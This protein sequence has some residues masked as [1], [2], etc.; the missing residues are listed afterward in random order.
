MEPQ[1]NL[2]DL[3]PE[4]ITE[5]LYNI[6][7]L[8]TLANLCQTDKRI[9]AICENNMFWKEKYRR[10]F[11]HLPSEVNLSWKE[12]YKL[13]LLTV[14]ISPISS[15]DNSYAIIDDQSM[16]YIGGNINSLTAISNTSPF[17]QKVRSVSQASTYTG[18]VTDDGKV[19]FWGEKLQTIFNDPIVRKPTEFKIPG[20]A[21]KISCGPIIGV[22]SAMFAVILEDRSV[23]LRMR[24]YFIDSGPY[25]SKGGIFSAKINITGRDGLKRNIKALDISTN[26]H[27]LAIVSTSGKLYYLGKSLNTNTVPYP[28][29][30]GDVGIIYKDGEIVVNPVHIHLP[31]T[32]KQVSLDHTHI[33]VL[34]FKGT[35]YLWG[36]NQYGQL[37]Q[38]K[39]LE[40]VNIVDKPLKLTLPVPIS[41][42]DCRYFT[43]SAIDKNGKLY[44]WGKHKMS[45][46]PSKYTG[47]DDIL[48][49]SEYYLNSGFNRPI[50]IGLR[51]NNTAM[52]NIFNYVSIGW[53]HVVATTNDGYVNVWGSI[54]Y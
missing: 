14:P 9:H 35:I 25:S 17:Q 47:F 29:T 10:Y 26:G 31:E 4:T 2:S 16:L 44:I 40:M 37:G 32:I 34:S 52:K 36:S 1:L 19:H 27:A 53:T 54:G 48:V 33:G 45:T 39:K 6:K 38:E 43:T 46:D 22:S 30:R 21:I 20:K 24:Y 42:I 49:S 50:E 23:F 18:A 28:D 13:A 15:N 5:L 8:K 51:H 41:F 3:P 7:D 11:K 12:M